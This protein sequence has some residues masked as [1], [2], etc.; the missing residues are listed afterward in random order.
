MVL[1]DIGQVR[2]RLPSG[3][4]WV[5]AFECENLGGAGAFISRVDRL[6][7]NRVLSDKKGISDRKGKLR[8]PLPVYQKPSPRDV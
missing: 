2:P 8:D 3:G 5:W 1:L 4:R 7:L 6:F